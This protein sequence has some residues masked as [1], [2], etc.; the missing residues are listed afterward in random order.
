MTQM[1]K[2]EDLIVRDKRVLVRV[3]FNVPI[4]NGR[5]T[6][7]LRIEAALP[8]IQYLLSQRAKVILASHLGRPDGKPDQK[9]SLEPV[10][11]LLSK[12]LKREVLFLHDCVG[13]DIEE[14][15]MQMRSGQVALLEN[16]RYHAEEEAGD[17]TFARGLAN[18][19]EVY[20]DDAFAVA[21]RAH[22][23]VVGVPKLLPHAAGKLLQAEVSTLTGLMA[24]PKKPFVAIIGG[25]KISDK[26]EFMK[27]LMKKADTIVISG[28]MANTF[29]AAQGHN[30]RESVLDKKGFAVAR[31]IL[32]TAQRK[33]I[34]V[35]LP[36][37]VVVASS[38]SSKR[39]RTVTVGQLDDGDMALD[40]GPAS[41]TNIHVALQD[42]QT[43]FWN[44]TLGYTEE[45]AFRTASTAVAKTIASSKALSVI[46]GGDTAGFIDSIGMN[47]KFGFVSTGGGAA[48]ELLSGKKLPAVVA[49]SR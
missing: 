8:T 35:I 14:K 38:P 37:D 7:E 49:L 25:A 3:D 26:I 9:Y 45:E 48:L 33:N 21:H 18:L 10:A 5:V 20:V 12:L 31:E 34:E 41:T 23:S 16:L 27:N 13:E 17:A 44:G 40:I 1:K 2:L 28:A 6:D 42:A 47:S 32:A 36:V 19:G 30:M 24:A 46:G 39:T 22:A 43:I 11:V 4:H 15:V 29:L